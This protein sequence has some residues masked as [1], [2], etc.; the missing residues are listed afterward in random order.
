[1][2][3]QDIPMLHDWLN[4]P[5][6]VEWWGGGEVPPTIDTVVK[7]Y[8]PRIGGQQSVKP[9]IAILG[10]EP[11]GYAQSYVAAESPAV[12]MRQTREEYERRQ[13]SV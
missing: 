4:R 1:M 5:H 6:I 2:K 10:E 12:Y 7:K 9:Y 13:L 8:L 11:I 3:E